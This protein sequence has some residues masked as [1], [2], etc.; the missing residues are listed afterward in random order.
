[1]HGRV[2]IGARG[3][4]TSAVRVTVLTGSP[5]SGSA[6]LCPPLSHLPL[7]GQPSDG[8]RDVFLDQ[9]IPAQRLVMALEN[10]GRIRIAAVA[11][12]DSEVSAQPANAGTLHRASLEKCPQLV[13][14]PPPEIEQARRSKPLAGLP[15]LVHGTHGGGGVVI[16][17]DV[18]A[19]IAAIGVRAEQDA[20]LLDNRA[21]VLDREIGQASCRIEHARF[22]QRSGRTRGETQRARSALIEDGLVRLQIEVADD[23]REEDPRTQLGVDQAG[24]LA[25]PAQTGVLRVDP[26]LHRPG[27]DISARFE[28][29]A[30]DERSRSSRTSSRR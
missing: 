18:L 14:G 5:A 19:D 30:E 13:V 11:D 1:M 28:P 27:I 24:V 10:R 2:T 23:F 4:G 16:R 20:L 3:D 25:D 22:D 8:P 7:D 26:L 17:A 6:G 21:L 9:R 29:F 15:G 12:G